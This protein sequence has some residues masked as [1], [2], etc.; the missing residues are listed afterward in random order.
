MWAEAKLGAKC[1]GREPWTKADKQWSKADTAFM[2]ATLA[3]E[4]A[5]AAALAG[6]GGAAPP[7]GAP[8]ARAQEKAAAMGTTMRMANYK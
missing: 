4:D 3:E 5:A 6:A 1:G 8:E 2:E 7:A